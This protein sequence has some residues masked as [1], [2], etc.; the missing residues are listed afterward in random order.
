MNHNKVSVERSSSSSSLFIRI[1]LKS[2]IAIVTAIC[3]C[4]GL[5]PEEERF[6]NY[7]VSQ[8]KCELLL[9]IGHY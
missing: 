9:V 5:R 4:I 1:I 2:G 6:Q 8:K 7:K 3:N